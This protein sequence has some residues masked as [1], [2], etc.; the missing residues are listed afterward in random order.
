MSTAYAA[1]ICA[2]P[3]FD[4]LDAEEE[5]LSAHVHEATD[6]SAVTAL[7]DATRRRLTQ[8]VDAVIRSLPTAIRS[9]LK[10]SREIAYALVG[11]ADERMLHHPT[12][13]L[14]RWRDRLLELELYDSALAGQ[15]I[16]SRAQSASR[17][18]SG[19]GIS[20]GDSGELALLAPLYLGVFRAGF[21]GSLRGDPAVLSSLI[22]SLEETIGVRHETPVQM[23]VETR[24]KRLGL[25][26]AVLA[27]AGVALWLASGL[28]VWHLLAGETLA[29]SAH[30]A[31]RISAGLPANKN[32][33]PMIRS[34]GP[35][36]NRDDANGRVK[37]GPV[38]E[39]PDG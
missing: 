14:D 1:A 30:L 3:F 13:G 8:G 17:G 34:F 16:V 11:L 18:N 33:G 19:V 20:S 9:D 38:Q 24:P 4:L 31:D 5:S 25:S 26:P 2:V 28:V 27:F 39:G 6:E 37:A 22:A 36:E 7:M 10:L 15:E 35:T 21:E 12:G 32:T 23:D 29:R